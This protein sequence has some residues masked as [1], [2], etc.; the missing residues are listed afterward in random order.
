MKGCVFGSSGYS[1]F[2]QLPVGFGF[3]IG[4]AGGGGSELQYRRS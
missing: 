1:S 4:A 3:V 2:N